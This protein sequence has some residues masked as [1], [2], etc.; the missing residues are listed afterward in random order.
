MIP[1]I[2]GS[3]DLKEVLDKMLDILLGLDTMLCLEDLVL[4]AEGKNKISVI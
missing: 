1:D 4:D 2:V 3:Y